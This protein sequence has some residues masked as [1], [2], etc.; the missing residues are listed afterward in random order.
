MDT[1]QLDRDGAVAI[2]RLNRP[3]VNAVNKTMM[4]EL[5]A[6]FDEVSQDRSVGAAVLAATGEKAFCGGI[7]LKETAV[8]ARSDTEDLRA[9]LDPAWEWRQTQYSIREC[10]VPVIG[11]IERAAIG[12]GFG[13][14]GVCDLV[15]AGEDA[16]FGLTEINVGLLGGASKA[17]RLLGPSKAR[18]MLFLGE[19]IPAAELHRLGGVE[20][21]VPAGE[22][23]RR[24][25]AMATQMASKSP[26]ALRLAKES[27]LRIEGD[28][29]MQRYRTENDYTNRLR[30]FNDSR[31]AM[32]AFIDKRPPHWT[33]T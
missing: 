23:E 24:A 7:D 4:R 2:I 32:E 26:L 9:L 27:I 16:T 11:A 18:R 5:R 15:I 12:A 22:A 8:E 1:L 14:T 13:L 25:V 31:E 19:L 30:A 28:E 3:P 6:C 10:L 29:M 33:W 17:L 21:V 20:E